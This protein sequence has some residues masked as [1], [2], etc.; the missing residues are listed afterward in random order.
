VVLGDALEADVVAVRFA[1]VFRVD[2]DVVRFAAVL[3]VVPD[4]FAED[5]RVE[6]DDFEDAEAVFLAAGF[7]PPLLEREEE[8]FERLLGFFGVAMDD[9]YLEAL[10]IRRRFSAPCKRKGGPEAAPLSVAQ[11]LGSGALL[12]ST[13]VPAALLAAV[14][15]AAL[16]GGAAAFFN[17]GCGCLR[18]LQHPSLLS[19]GIP[20]LPARGAGKTRGVQV[21][22]PCARDPGTAAG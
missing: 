9:D 21:V 1:V 19:L 11:S 16:L 14:I 10:R 5:P 20:A 7:F 22:R 2:P 4:D 12:A 8:L 15:S 13:L 3:R 18:C 6:P 17:I